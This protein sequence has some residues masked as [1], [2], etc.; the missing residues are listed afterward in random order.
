M[1]LEKRRCGTPKAAVALQ[2][3]LL[4]GT[5]TGALAGGSTDVCG[6]W[7]VYEVVGRPELAHSPPPSSALS[8]DSEQAAALHW[9]AWCISALSPALMCI[10]SSQSCTCPHTHTTPQSRWHHVWLTT[11]YNIIKTDVCGVAKNAYYSF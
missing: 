6:A 10:I 3:A 2:A 8:L 9:S 5:V 4:E 7:S 1:E 11:Q